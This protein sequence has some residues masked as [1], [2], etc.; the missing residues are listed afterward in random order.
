MKKILVFIFSTGFALSSLAQTADS[1]STMGG[2]SEVYYSFANGIVKTVDN[3]TW[4]IAFEMKGFLSAIQVNEQAGAQLYQTPFVVADWATVDT[5]GMS[6]WEVTRNSTE[7]WSEGAFNSNISSEYDLGWGQYDFNTHQVKGDSIFLMR[8][9]SGM[10]KKIYIKSLANSTY[11]F[12]Y[13]DVDGSNEMTQTI[14]KADFPGVNFAYYDFNGNS[15]LNREPATTDWDIVFTKYP[16]AIPA[17]PQTLYYPVVGVKINKGSEAAERNGVDV[18]SN[19]TN[20]LTWTTNITEIGS[21]WKTFN[22]TDYDIVEDQTFFV[23][24]QT[25]AVWKMYFT[26]YV[27]GPA[28]TSYFTIENI[29]GALSTQTLSSGITVFPNPAQSQFQVENLNSS[30]FSNLSLIDQ[31]GRIVKSWDLSQSYSLVGI[32]S[33]LYYLS[34][35]TNSSNSVLPLLVK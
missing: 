2:S 21:D 35:K 25:G 5:A 33:G 30:N 24:T 10:W 1:A 32:P 22:N 27:G 19:D 12:V 26:A 17:G 29:K 4:D 16:V 3:N 14:V 9:R 20:S 7:T 31:T 6:A 34:V 28:A 13:A 8:T 18:S 23:R 11:T 15:S